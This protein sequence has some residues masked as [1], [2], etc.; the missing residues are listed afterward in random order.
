MQIKIVVVILTFWFISLALLLFSFFDYTIFVPSNTYKYFA[1]IY[2]FIAIGFFIYKIYFDNPNLKLKKAS[3][4]SKPIIAPLVFIVFIHL[5]L[6]GLFSGL[7][8][9]LQ[10]I[11]SDMIVFEKRIVNKSYANGRPGNN[12]YYQIDL[13]H[14]FYYGRVCTTKNV[15]D[16]VK[17]GHTIEL[18]GKKNIFGYFSKT[19]YLENK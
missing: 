3:S 17:T 14:S 18:R 7:P 13:E 4:L 8:N 6:V 5:S 9:L 10:Y 2:T 15:L 16:S 1:Y 12:C 19:S 11:P